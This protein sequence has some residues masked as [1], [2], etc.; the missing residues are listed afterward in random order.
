MCT[1]LEK[2][3]DAGRTERDKELV[4]E[5]TRDGYSVEMM[6]K[7]LKKSEEFVRKIQEESGVLSGL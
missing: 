4:I 7:L 6:A 3:K 2:L 5:W 1:A